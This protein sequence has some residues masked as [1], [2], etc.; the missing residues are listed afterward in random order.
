MDYSL[1]VGVDSQKNEL[2]VGIVGKLNL[3]SS[4]TPFNVHQITFAH[5]L[6]T[7]NWRLCLRSPDSLVA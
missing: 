5:T 2:V 6:W 7:R 3:Y 4:I 1:V